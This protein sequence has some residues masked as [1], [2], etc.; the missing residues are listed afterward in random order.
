MKRVKKMNT[1]K[2]EAMI[3]NSQV[4]KLVEEMEVVEQQKS[5]KSTFVTFYHDCENLYNAE[6]YIKEEYKGIS[7]SRIL[8]V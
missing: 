1:Y 5:L 8:P 7:I 4:E 3:K 6:Q 2:I